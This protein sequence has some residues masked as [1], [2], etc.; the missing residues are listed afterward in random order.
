MPQGVR[1]DVTRDAGRLG[2]PA[3]HPCRHRA[4]RSGCE[5]AG[6]GSAGQWSACRDRAPGRSTGTVIGIVGGLLPCRR[7]GGRGAVASLEHQGLVALGSRERQC[8][9]ESVSKEAGHGR[10]PRHSGA[11]GPVRTASTRHTA[12]CASGPDVVDGAVAH[13]VWWRPRR[14]PRRCQSLCR[15]SLALRST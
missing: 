15:S 1:A 3:D 9:V 8:E 4:G 11:P 13:T 6:A 7:A 5:P 2:R 10:A 14:R 12:R